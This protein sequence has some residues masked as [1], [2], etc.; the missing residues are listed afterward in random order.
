MFC[1]NVQTFSYNKYYKSI[2]KN[3]MKENT[4]KHYIVDA[5]GIAKVTAR[6]NDEKLTV[7]QAERQLKN[8]SL[9]PEFINNIDWSMLIGQKETLLSIQNLD[10]VV[11]SE[12]NDIDAI[13]HLLDA[14]QDFAADKMGLGEKVVFGTDENECIICGNEIDHENLKRSLG[15]FSPVLTSKCC[16]ARCYTKKTTGV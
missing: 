12:K 4:G 15:D 6:N 2:K 5:L 7:Q 14:L 16:S 1:N 3:I 11:N 10:E 13:I 9:T 8:L